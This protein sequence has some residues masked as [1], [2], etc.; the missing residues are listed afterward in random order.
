MLGPLKLLVHHRSFYDWKLVKATDVQKGD[1]A[2]PSVHGPEFAHLQIQYN[3]PNTTEIGFSE[4]DLAQT[5]ADHVEGVT[6]ARGGYK[7]KQV[8]G[9]LHGHEVEV[10]A[11]NMPLYSRNEFLAKHL[12]EAVFPSHFPSDAVTKI[13]IVDSALDPA[14]I[15]KL[16]RF[17]NRRF[18]VDAEDDDQPKAKGKK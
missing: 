18:V 6:K 4:T 11:R 12:A 8:G 5:H 10:A 2:L 14:D 13:E 3:E 9:P 16:E 1:V 15:R 7:A 17:L